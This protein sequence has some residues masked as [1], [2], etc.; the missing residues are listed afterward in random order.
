MEQ[1]VTGQAQSFLFYYVL[2]AQ[3]LVHTNTWTN[4]MPLDAPRMRMSSNGKLAVLLALASCASC[5]W[6][7]VQLAH[8][9][10]G[11]AH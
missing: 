8:Y 3:A 5:S 1:T 4:G 9:A 7:P 6:C 11:P 10:I 2:Q